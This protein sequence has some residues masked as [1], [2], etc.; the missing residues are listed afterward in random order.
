[1]KKLLSILLISMSLEAY[2]AF[3][4]EIVNPCV[5]VPSVFEE[6]DIFAP[7]KMNEVVN[8]FFPNFGIPY[9]A[10]ESSMLHIFHTPYGDEAMEM[11]NSNHFRFYGWC[12]SVDGVIPDVT[13]D[14]FTV[15]PYYVHHIRWFYGF[16]E[17]INGQWGE[18]CQALYNHP[19]R[20]ICADK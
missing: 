20:F 18:Y 12:Y 3:W 14:Q 7:A 17:L 5:N 19:D 11:V 8:F 9:L 2:C 4:I 6:V 1:M 13:M 16:V 15:D 10:T